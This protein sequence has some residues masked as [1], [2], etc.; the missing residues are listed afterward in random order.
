[1]HTIISAI[2]VTSFEI[3]FKILTRIGLRA[4]SDLLGS[5]L[6]NDSTAAVAALWPEVDDMVSYLYDVEVMLDNE[7]GIALVGKLTEHVDKLVHVSGMK[8]RSWLVEDI[9]SLAR[10]A[11]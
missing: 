5:S 7:H 11:F 9:D 3:G 6:C 4:L 8:S 2:K 1:M 10:S